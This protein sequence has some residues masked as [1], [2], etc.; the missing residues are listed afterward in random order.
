MCMSRRVMR[1][2]ECESIHTHAA[3]THVTNSRKNY[4]CAERESG[5]FVP[6]ASV[7]KNDTLE[8]LVRQ[9]KTI[10][11]TKH[12]MAS[13]MRISGKRKRRNE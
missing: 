12:G 3:S 11:E 7:N 5:G 13:M 1:M 4:V 6:T 8:L 9:R 2:S 10:E